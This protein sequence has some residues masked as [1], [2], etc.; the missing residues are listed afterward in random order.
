MTKISVILSC[1]SLGVAPQLQG[2]PTL[3]A[4]DTTTTGDLTFTA[5]G[6]LN[7]PNPTRGEAGYTRTLQVQKDGVNFGTASTTNT[8]TVTKSGGGTY[9]CIQ[10]ESNYGGT[11]SRTSDPVVV[12]TSAAPSIAASDS[13]SGNDLTITVTS[14]SGIPTPT[15]DLTTLTLD[16]VDV[17]GSVVTADPWEYIVPES[18]D[19]QT[20]LWE[21]TATNGVGSDATASGSEVIPGTAPTAQN[22]LIDRTYTEGT[23]VK[24]VDASVDFSG[25]SLVYSVNSLTGVSINSATGVVSIDTDAT[26]PLSSAAI[27]VTATNNANSATSGFSATVQATAVSTGPT[28]VGNAV[29]VIPAGNTNY[30]INLPAGLA[31]GDVI[32]LALCSDWN[33]QTYTPTATGITWTAVHASTSGYPAMA[34]WLGVCGSNPNSTASINM[35]SNQGDPQVAVTQAFRGVDTAQVQDVTAVVTS[36]NTGMPDCGTLTTVTDNALSV[37]VG[38]LDDDEVAAS[39]SAPTGYSNLVAG[40]CTAATAFIASKLV[41]SAGA[42][43]PSAFVAALGD[44]QWIGVHLALRASG[45]SVPATAPAAFTSGQW[46]LTNAASGGQLNVGIVSLPSDGGAAITDIKYRINGGSLVSTG[47]TSSFS[48]TGLTNGASV[49]VEIFATNSVGD[50]AASDTKN[51]TPTAAAAVPSAFTAGD[52]TATD[53]Q[54]GGRINVSIASLPANNGATITGIKYRLNSGSWVSTGGTGSFSITGLTDGSSYAIQ[55]LATNSVGDGPASDTKTRTPTTASTGSGA[56]PSAL[57]TTTTATILNGWAGTEGDFTGFS[58]TTGFTQVT[59]T[60]ADELRAAIEAH[61]PN[62][63]NDGRVIINCQWNGNSSG[64]NRWRGPTTTQLNTNASAPDGSGYDRGNGAIW[65]RPATGYTPAL[66]NPNIIANGIPRLYIEG[67]RFN[68]TAAGQNPDGV[69]NLFF[70]PVASFPIRDLV[71]IKNCTFGI[72]DGGTNPAAYPV[73]IKTNNTFGLH[74]ENCTFDGTREAAQA[75]SKY[76]KAIRNRI[77]NHVSDVFHHSGFQTWAGN[78]YA[79]VEYNVCDKAM[80]NSGLTGL[81]TDFF[82]YGTYVDSHTSYNVLVRNNLY[83]MG[84]FDFDSNSQGVYGDDCPSPVIARLV[85]VDNVLAFNAYWMTSYHSPGGTGACVVA[86]NIS[87]RSGVVYEVAQDPFP[88]VIQTSLGST[89][90]VTNIEITNNVLTTLANINA[91]G[92]TSGNVYVSPRRNVVSGTGTTSTSPLRHEAYFNHGVRD[93]SDNLTYSIAGEGNTDYAT[94]F[95]IL[96]DHFRPQL[97]YGNSGANDPASWPNA[98][99][100]P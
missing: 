45:Q 43:N 73:A 27:V 65:I 67:M 90:S 14:V 81:H 48:I 76:F 60:S 40:E 100:H 36:G 57:E 9:T 15:Y 25:P 1:T 88:R 94:A 28:V 3:T 21:V 61:R 85:V 35:V 95:H 89:Q 5:S 31:Q 98:P 8:V 11:A 66:S 16:G 39:V 54:T 13:L 17:S 37:A 80:V 18:E 38:F 92:N 12:G 62:W 2:R 79:L 19:P 32:V 4:G 78:C 97:G 49:A 24:T 75:T 82:Q 52:W 46:T 47:G 96:A 29:T 63:R 53:A 51:N 50:S 33:T 72:A 44:D 22:G 87:C 6:L 34:C 99:A 69:Y 23:G 91:A 84:T 41:A 30:T 74:V 59:A 71:A 70:Y 56:T 20:V 93:G 26:G 68:G 77:L 10:T 7:T 55:L 86:R 64:N 83:H 42:E 58:S